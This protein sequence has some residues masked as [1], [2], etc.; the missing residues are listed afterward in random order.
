M[1]NAPSNG[2]AALVEAEPVGLDEFVASLDQPTGY[3]SSVP[4][5]A[6]ATGGARGNRAKKRGGTSGGAS[7][8]DSRGGSK[9]S[10]ASSSCA[11]TGGTISSLRGA[12]TSWGVAT[13]GE[14]V[15]EQVPVAYRCWRIDKKRLLGPSSLQTTARA[16]SPGAASGRCGSPSGRTSAVVSG[17]SVEAVPVALV[18]LGGPSRNIQSCSAS[19]STAARDAACDVGL[20]SNREGG[21]S[22]R[23][24]GVREVAAVGDA[25]GLSRTGDSPAKQAPGSRVVTEPIFCRPP[26]ESDHCYVVLE[27]LPSSARVLEGWLIFAL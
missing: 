5:R 15:A 21:A 14:S 1:G 2:A 12:A 23:D 6:G 8:R 10:S 3:W 18:Q 19:S 4:S 22:C 27:V 16:V 9:A 20:A 24:G 13:G 11:R 25:E 17:P 26:V 7:G